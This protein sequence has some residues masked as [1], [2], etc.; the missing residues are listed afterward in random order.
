MATKS[1]T[2]QIEDDDPGFVPIDGPDGRFWVAFTGSRPEE[3]LGFFYR[4]SRARFCFYAKVDPIAMA[5]NV[6][7]T[8]TGMWNGPYFKTTADSEAIFR[9]NI[10]F[11]FATRRATDPARMGDGSAGPTIFS[12][13]IF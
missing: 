2:P 8:S 3:P 12:W 6:S 4:D 9:R 1:S 5:W 7:R 10:A 11:F 13:K